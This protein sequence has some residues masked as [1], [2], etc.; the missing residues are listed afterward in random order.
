MPG[1]SFAELSG[2]RDRDGL[3]PRSG[4][5]ESRSWLRCWRGAYSVRPYAAGASG[6]LPLS[7][8]RFL[9]EPGCH[10]GLRSTRRPYGFAS[11]AFAGFAVSRSDSVRVEIQ[12]TGPRSEPDPLYRPNP[13]RYSVLAP[14]NFRGSCKLFQELL[15]WSKINSVRSAAGSRNGDQR[16]A[17]VVGELGGAPLEER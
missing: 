8:S 10:G 2:G 14:E 6:C 9:R 5:L 3:E 15:L 12:R 11:P 17:A 4:A 7:Q 16:L 1:P 13:V